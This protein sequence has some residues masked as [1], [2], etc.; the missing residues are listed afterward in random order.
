MREAM[1][2]WHVVAVAGSVLICDS[3]WVFTKG[4]MDS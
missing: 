2:R 3:T 1:G 4:K